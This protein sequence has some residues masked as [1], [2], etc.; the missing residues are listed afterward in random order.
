MLVLFI[1]DL[2]ISFH[3]ELKTHMNTSR[4]LKRYNY[5]KLKVKK[6]N[7]VVTSFLFQR[8]ACQ[9]VYKDEVIDEVWVRY[10]YSLKQNRKSKGDV[11]V[12]WF[13]FEFTSSAIFHPLLPNHFSILVFAHHHLYTFL[14]YFTISL[15]SSISVNIQK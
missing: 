3:A 10:F 7:K 15:P 5:T 1:C 13:A 2:K 6:I 11:H 8:Y 14:H 4:A 9:T 12:R